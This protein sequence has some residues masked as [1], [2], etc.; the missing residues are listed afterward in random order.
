MFTYG[1]TRHKRAPTWHETP[2]FLA[3]QK[4]WYSK[5]ERKGFR[6]IEFLD[7]TG[8]TDSRFLRGGDAYHAPLRYDASREEYYRL[9]NQWVWEAGRTLKGL[10]RK[11]WRAHAE[12]LSYREIREKHVCSVDKIMSVVK[13]ERVRMRQAYRVDG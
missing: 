5:L 13:R 12:G 8:S 7:T 3:L 1:H 4:A 6:D 2:E 10:D 11:I 9:A